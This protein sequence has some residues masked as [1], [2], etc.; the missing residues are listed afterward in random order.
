MV[1]IR[2]ATPYFSCFFWVSD[3]SQVRQGSQVEGTAGG[4]GG[5]VGAMVKPWRNLIHRFH[6]YFSQMFLRKP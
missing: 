3:W 5:S 4:R 2:E 1:E 6:G